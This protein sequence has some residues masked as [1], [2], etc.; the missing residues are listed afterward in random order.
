MSGMHLAGRAERLGGTVADA[1]V[2][3]LLV[4]GCLVAVAALWLLGMPEPVVLAA[5]AAPLALLVG[6]RAPVAALVTL[7]VLRTL[8]DDVGNQAVT[9]GI[10]VAVIGLAALVAPRSTRWLAPAALVATCSFASAW[11]GAGTHGADTTYPEALRVLSA[12]AVV[13]VAAYGPTRLGLPGARG[14][15]QLAGVVPAV[16]AV[17]QWATGTGPV[18]NGVMRSTGT[19]AH[20]NSAAALFA[21]CVLVTFSVL[22]ERRTGRALQL[23]LL[24]TFLAALVS[25]GS[26]GGF[27]ATLAM[28]V[29]YLFSRAVRRA[30]RIAL[31]VVG[32]AAVA[33]AAVASP[34]GAGRLEEY[35]GGSSDETSLEWRLQA[36]ETVL[37]AWRRHVALGNGLGSTQANTIL[38]GNI[39][40]NEYVRLLA[41]IGVVGLAAVVVCAVLFAR[42]IARRARTSQVPSAASL[43]HAV[44][45]GTAVNALAANS[46]LYTSSFYLTL[47]LLASCWRA[48][49]SPPPA[50][51]PATALPGTTSFT[52]RT[53][54]PDAFR[55]KTIT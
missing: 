41:E 33:Y 52:R 4:G 7:L 20:P 10:A 34:V 28:C 35:S 6:Y 29:V 2:P 23:A 16:M 43:A 18:N 14:V 51:P 21:L 47:F 8:L 22:V 11:A 5:A 26:I 9:G 24:G 27:T 38:V 1:A 53:T 19:L 46:M 31:G 30:D 15:V 40:H 44:L 49:A 13:V 48:T 55:A 45:A 3:L 54:R 36:W 17:V 42:A 12:G 39:P 25:T 37:A 32:L 50:P